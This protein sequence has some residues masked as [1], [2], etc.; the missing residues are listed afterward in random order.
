LKGLQNKMTQWGHSTIPVPFVGMLP[1]GLL[2][3]KAGEISRTLSTANVAQMMDNYQRLTTAIGFLE[4]LSPPAIAE[5][6]RKAGA[7]VG[8]YARMSPFEKDVMTNVVFFYGWAKTAMGAFF[9]GLKEQPQMMANFAKARLMAEQQFGVGVPSTAVPS[10]LRGS[11]FATELGPSGSAVFLS[12][13]TPDLIG[14]NYLAM[15]E[16]IVRQALPGA[17][18]GPMGDRDVGDLM[19]PA[20][21]SVVELI[22]NVDARWGGPSFIAPPIDPS[23]YGSIAQMANVARRSAIGKV[24]TAPVSRVIDQSI[25]AYDMINMLIDNGNYDSAI[26]FAAAIRAS[27]QLGMS[28]PLG[29][30]YVGNVPRE[31]AKS[32]RLGL[33]RASRLQKEMARP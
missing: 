13:Q 12:P 10:Y 9:A 30:K 27:R 11:A 7:F 19:P 33:E 15:A 1:F 28:N 23:N 17:I 32:E 4:D 18:D 3:G 2:P 26:A 6:I 22:L 5:A 31:M 14:A 25:A 16:G 21:R 29:P 20:V 8:N 24:A